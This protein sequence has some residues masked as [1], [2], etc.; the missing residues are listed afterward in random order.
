M[1]SHAYCAARR[2]RVWCRTRAEPSAASASTLASTLALVEDG[3]E[4]FTFHDSNPAAPHHLLVIPKV[5]IRDALTLTHADA[6][7]VRRMRRK[8]IE[9]M[10]AAVVEAEAEVKGV[11]EGDG[12]GGGE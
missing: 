5:L 11:A 12:R 6:P 7:L 10:R 9:Q 2:R 3:E 1:C 4:L 8:A